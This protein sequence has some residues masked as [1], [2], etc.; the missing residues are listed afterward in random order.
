MEPRSLQRVNDNIKSLEQLRAYRDKHLDAGKALLGENPGVYYSYLDIFFLA[1]I[2]RSY[3]LLRGFCD[4]IESRNFIA[5]SPF[6]RLQLDNCLRVAAP[7]WVADPL[8][9]GKEVIGGKQIDKMTDKTGKCRLKDLYLRE[10]LGKKYPWIT[11]LYEQASGFVH[12]SNKHIHDIVEMNSDPEY[13]IVL[14][15]SDC[16]SELVLDSTYI[17]ALDEFAKATDLLLELIHE[18]GVIRSR[19]RDYKE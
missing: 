5:A 12:F 6:V 14:A 16:D 17:G 9:F 1:V 7:H 13:G 3:F 10:Q 15:L 8:L 2:H 19:S 18:W 4:L 11:T